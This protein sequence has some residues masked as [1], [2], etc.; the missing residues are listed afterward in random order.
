MPSILS[1]V[2]AVA[3]AVPALSAAVV[4]QSPAA[5]RRLSGPIAATSDIVDTAVAAK[6]ETL[7]A[8]VRAAGLV[9]TLKGDGPFTR[10][11]ADGTRLRGTSGRDAAIAAAAR[12]PRPTPRRARASC[13][14]RERLNSYE[15]AD[16]AEPQL[17]RTAERRPPSGSPPTL[18]GFRFGDA[19]VVRADIACTNGVVHVI[20]RVVVP[21]ASRTEE[22]MK[23]A[24]KERAPTSLLDALRAVPDGRVLDVPLGRRRGRRRPGLG[25]SLPR[26]ELDGLRSDERGV[27]PTDGE[28]TRRAVRPK[29]RDMLRKLLDWHAIPEIQAWSFDDDDKARGPTMISREKGV[30]SRRA[31]ERHGV[32]LHAP[33]QPERQESFRARITAGDI[34]IGGSVVHVIDRVLV[35]PELENVVVASQSY[36]EAEVKDMA[37]GAFA[38]FRA[39]WV[40]KDA[41]AEAEALDDAAAVAVYSLGLR[42]TEDVVPVIRNGVMVMPETGRSRREALRNR[43]KARIDELDRVWYA[44]FTRTARR[45]GASTRFLRSDPSAT[46]SSMEWRS[47]AQRAVAPPAIAP[48]TPTES[49]TPAVPP[50]LEDGAKILEK[51]PIPSSS[52]TRDCARPS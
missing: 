4:P 29:N 1:F 50:S 30:R 31:A 9:D 26:R 12:K 52:R 45:P 40:L 24:M 33:P 43:L 11:R 17:A 35:P 3:L 13:R 22:G 48:S 34:E 25:E 14:C 47:S 39:C 16:I 51:N 32:R 2:L 19:N 44:K 38:C 15:V 46:A 28:R 27:Q 37:A 23:F 10:L 20:D 18:A 21:K 42:I 36:R 6:L 49:K 7:V 41:L 8:A 5:P